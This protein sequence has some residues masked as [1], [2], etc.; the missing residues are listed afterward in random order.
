MA[1]VYVIAEHRDG[2]LKKST[3]ELLGASSAAGN[4]THAI[5]LGDGIEA[6]AKELGQ[7][8][9]KTVHLAQNPALKFYTAEAYTAV[10]AD[11]VKGAD[12]VLASHTPTGR[13]FMPK[14]AARLGV[15]LASDCTQLAFS[16]SKITVRRPVY[17][18]KATVEVEFVGSGPR[19]ATIRANA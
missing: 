9:A 14:L 5:L 3:Y 17:A 19:L 4:D 13:D 15:G 8:G 10:I 18:G 7:Y 11:L 1:K 6:L 12:V 16:G 2:R